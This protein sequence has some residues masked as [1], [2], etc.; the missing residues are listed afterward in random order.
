MHLPE[1]AQSP[2]DLIAT[3][4]VRPEPLRAAARLLLEY[5]EVVNAEPGNLRFEAYRDRE[6]GFIVVVERYASADAFEAHLANPANAK[7]NAQ[8]S[9]ILRGGGST[10]QMLDPLD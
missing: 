9:R 8:L 4:E 2:I 1:A 10:L 7:F 5:G 3:I 6:S